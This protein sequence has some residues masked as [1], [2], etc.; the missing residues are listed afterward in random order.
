[1]L[2][3]KVGANRTRRACN[4]FPPRCPGTLDALDN[5]M[6]GYEIAAC[7]VCAAPDAVTI[8]N[9][10]DIR[11]EMEQL[12]AFH[13]ARLRQSVPPALLRD[14][15]AFSQDPP[16]QIVRC[17]GCSLLYRNPRERAAT[18]IET[19]RTEHMQTES[20]QALFDNQLRIA[21]EQAHTLTRVFGRAATGLEIGS[22]TGA[23]LAAADDHGWKFS[24][25]DVNESAVA[26]ARTRGLDATVGSIDDTDGTFDVVA[27]WN[28]FDQLPDPLA[29]AHAARDRLAPGGLLVLRVP[30]GAFYEA[31]RARLDSPLR[32]LARAVLAHNNLLGFPYRHGFSPASLRTLLDSV[33]CRVEQIRPDTLVPVA[34]YYTRSWAAREER[35]L[36]AALRIAHAAPWLE[37]YARAI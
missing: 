36:K 22:Y 14:R 11:R 15:I 5:H 25:V 21:R 18:L 10:E 37:V 20:L 24:G 27:F 35:V 1:L 32:F 19:Y 23:F 29:A 33:K 3:D 2:S 6:T 13:M 16:L 8:A 17:T 4:G 9:T 28:C 26:F 31:W 7:P 30:N 34:D 12:W